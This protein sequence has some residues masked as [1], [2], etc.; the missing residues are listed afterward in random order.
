M[1]VDMDSPSSPARVTDRTLDAR[2]PIKSGQ[3]GTANVHQRAPTFAP[4][5]HHNLGTDRI[6]TLSHTL[7]GEQSKSK[8]KPRPSWFSKLRV[9][10]KRQYEQRDQPKSV[11]LKESEER[12]VR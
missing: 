9:Q 6:H 7:K 8:L 3:E 11:K 2:S 10:Y 12:L 5:S 4:S 1:D